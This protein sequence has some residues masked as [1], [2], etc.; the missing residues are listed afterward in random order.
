MRYTTLL[1]PIFLLIAQI[2][3][4]QV[5]SSTQYGV[6][7]IGS[8]LVATEGVISVTATG[9]GAT[10]DASQLT[11]GT[12]NDA[13]LS[14]NVVSLTATQSLINKTLTAPRFING[15]YLSD[16]NGNEILKFEVP[17]SNTVNEFTIRSETAGSG[18]ALKATGADANIDLF[19]TPKGTGRIRSPKGSLPMSSIVV[20]ATE[21][22]ASNLRAAGNGTTDDA[23]AL[24]DA[25]YQGVNNPKRVVY[26]PAGT[27]KLN[28]GLNLHNEGLTIRGAGMHRTTIIVDAS[29]SGNGAVF[30]ADGRGDLAFEDLT[31]TGPSTGKALKA[32]IRLNSAPNNARR[33][34]FER[35]RINDFW[36]H[37]ILLGETG[38]T[39]THSL[40]DVVI[41]DCQFYNIGDPS[42]LQITEL[43]PA[44]T[45]NAIH[46]GQTTRKAIITGNTIYKVGGDG[47]FGWGWCQGG[48]TNEDFGNWLITNNHINYCWMAIE[49]NGNSLGR[50]LV[51]DNNVIKY[52]TRNQGYLLS[53][54]SRN[55]RVTNNTLINTDRG[56]IEATSIGGLFA[57]NVIQMSVFKNGSGGI[58]ATAT[59]ARVA[60]MELYGFNNTISGGSIT[61]DAR[62]DDNSFGS[63]E[64][65]GIKLI[66]R[67][68]DP[69]SQ[70]TSFDGITDLSGYWDIRDVTIH[71]FTHK[72]IDATNEKIRK[73]NITNNTFRSRNA[74][75]SPV[76]IF[77]YDWLVKNNTFDLTGSTPKGESGAVQ[78]F[79]L[80]VQAA[81]NTSSVVTGNTIINDAWKLIHTGQYRSFQNTFVKAGGL[82]YAVNPN[83]SVTQAERTAMTGVDEGTT[84]QQTDAGKGTYTFRSGSW[85]RTD[86]DGADGSANFAYQKITTSSTVTP[87]AGH[88]VISVD[89]GATAVSVTLNPGNQT[90]G[91]LV[92]IR[93]Y[94]ANSTADIQISGQSGTLMQNPGGSFQNGIILPTASGSRH[95]TFVYNGKN[96][97]LISQ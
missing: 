28:S 3:Y 75:E 77:G 69:A 12:L 51:I 76:Q 79:Y 96:Y 88:T 85:T 5:A 60:A 44:I 18:P 11:T 47:I 54:D 33:I 70:P 42:A 53:L 41:K 95:W 62:K 81:E 14:T 2:S 26:L 87:S 83:P 80:Q 56:V 25:I 84:V 30:T 73:V 59:Q 20:N 71:G 63:T 92:V 52:S 29:F 97:E 93:R 58:A 34:R 90:P 46:L 50:N 61:L 27:F 1:L 4:A 86:N 66:S 10:N 21:E 31:I 15:G 40:D 67:T 65:N 24:Q 38:A 89:N 57:N 22:T 9:G 72:A 55:L 82:T 64:Y 32:A 13:R 8:G 94:D 17:A 68:T 43:S 45:Y 19:L 49:I 16:N 6:V 39:E 78:V 23:A 48:S 37:G 74:L 36:G 91:Q 35:I 7:K